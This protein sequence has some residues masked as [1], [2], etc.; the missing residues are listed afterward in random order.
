MRANGWPLRAI[1]GALDVSH[2][3]IRKDLRR[4]EQAQAVSTPHVKKVD[5]KRQLSITES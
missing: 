4:S 2:E 5:R 3:T 1:A